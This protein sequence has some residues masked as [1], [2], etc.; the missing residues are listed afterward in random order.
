MTDLQ[1][2][3][4]FRLEEPGSVDVIAQARAEGR[5]LALQLEFPAPR[6]LMVTTA[7]SE[8]ARNILTYAKTGEIRLG[9]CS[10]G[11]RAG[12]SI[13]A[14]DEGPGIADL[15]E[16]MLAGYSSSGDPGLGLPGINRMADE[17][18]IESRPGHTL[19]RATFWAAIKRA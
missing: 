13:V 2:L 16:A 19:V 3:T 5:A 1:T 8:L 17:F 15:N 12:L 6:V 7:I 18:R 4:R 14:W 9:F 10:N 11:S